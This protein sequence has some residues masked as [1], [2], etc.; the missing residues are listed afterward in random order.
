[1]RWAAF[2][3]LVLCA[4]IT[5]GQRA[6]AQTTAQAAEPGSELTVYLVTIGVGDLV[7]ER[8]GHN[9]IWIS[10]PVRGT[11]IAYNWGLFAF[12]PGFVPNF[13]RG[14]MTYSMGPQLM[15]DQLYE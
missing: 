5:T 12:G 11:N 14:H 2:L 3:A 4:A 13:L 7:Y 8:F 1:M 9:A 6:S 10:D 15:N